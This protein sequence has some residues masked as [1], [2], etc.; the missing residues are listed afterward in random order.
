MVHCAPAA[1]PRSEARRWRRRIR[2]AWSCVSGGGVCPEGRVATEDQRVRAGKERG[3]PRRATGFGR[4]RR[5]GL[6][7][8]RD[9]RDGRPMSYMPFGLRDPSRVPWPPAMSSAATSPRPTASRVAR[10]Q[11][12]RVAGDAAET[13]SWACSGP[14]GEWGGEGERLR[15]AVRLLGGKR[16][17]GPESGWGAAHG[18]RGDVRRL[19]GPGARR[20]IVD[21]RSGPA[22]RERGKEVGP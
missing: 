8:R 3:G 14:P 6:A 16:K 4:R 15:P 18:D 1:A 22:R 7:C 20:G 13:R 19:V 11:P 17:G 10:S 21:L 5:R 12:S 2:S 9:F